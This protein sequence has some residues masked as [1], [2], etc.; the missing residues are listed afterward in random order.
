MGQKED[1]A[2]ANH[3][4][5]QSNKPLSQPPHVLHFNAVVKEL[6][7]DPDDG[8]TPAEA[9]ERLLEYGRNEFGDQPTV[10]LIQVIIAQLANMMTMVSFSPPPRF[11]LLLSS[12]RSWRDSR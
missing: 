9:A 12:A 1:P 5:G 3:I 7:T 8:L 11:S 2:V 6:R 4:S 10:S